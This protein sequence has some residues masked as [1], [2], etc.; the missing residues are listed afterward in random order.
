MYKVWSVSLLTNPWHKCNN[1]I[2]NVPF[3]CDTL[4][5]WCYSGVT[6]V[7]HCWSREVVVVGTEAIAGPASH[8]AVHGGRGGGTAVIS[9]SVIYHR[10]KNYYVKVYPKVPINVHIY[11]IYLISNTRLI[12]ISENYK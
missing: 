5:Q 8:R 11:I 12:N 10:T 7:L 9:S 4:L 3:G 1:Y 2:S 6:V